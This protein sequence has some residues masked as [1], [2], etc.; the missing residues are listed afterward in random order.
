MMPD[1]LQSNWLFLAYDGRYKMGA[2]KT[3]ATNT[4][5]GVDQRHQHWVNVLIL[6]HCP[7][8]QELKSH[9]LYKKYKTNTKQ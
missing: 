2:H 5:F 4:N 1:G 3:V 7:H 6:L 8:R 9:K